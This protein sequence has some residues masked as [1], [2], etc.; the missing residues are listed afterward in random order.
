MAFRAAI[1]DVDGVLVDSPHEQAWRDSLARL[2][3]GPWASIVGQTSYAPGRFTSAVYQQH[4][5]GKPREA[6]AHAALLYF[7]IPADQAHVQAYCDT[8]Q[9]QLLDLIARGEFT[10]FDDAIR[11]LLRFKAAGI[12]IASASSSRNADLFLQ[13]VPLARFAG[14]F[15]L[16]APGAPLLD[17]LDANVNGH[18]VAHG[19]PDPAIFLL[20][21][22]AL[23]LEPAGCVVV[24]DAPAGVQAAKAGGMACIAVAR[25][26]DAAALRAAGADWVVPQLDAL[27]SAAIRGVEKGD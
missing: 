10:A 26:D 11:L 14:E 18:A 7:G 4:V 16:F 1:F 20:A 27:P 23:H 25:H 3:A 9:A 15:G 19:K 22:A 24:E 12:R 8:K 13:R 17:M 6:G 2:M 5:A 21:A